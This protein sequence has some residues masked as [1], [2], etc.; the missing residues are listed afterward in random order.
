MGWAWP[1]TYVFSTECSHCTF[2]PGLC[3]SAPQVLQPGVPSGSCCLRKG[4][5]VLQGKEFVCGELLEEPCFGY[6]QGFPEQKAG[7]KK[8]DFLQPREPHLCSSVLTALG[9]WRVRCGQGCFHQRQ[10]FIERHRPGWRSAD[11]ELA[12]Q[13]T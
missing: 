9:T 12:T 10:L 13:T 7:W 11:K 2:N 8:P 1:L 4:Y 3:Y 5:H 6:P